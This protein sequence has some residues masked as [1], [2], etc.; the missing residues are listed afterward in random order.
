MKGE[1]KTG[2]WI[3][4]YLSAWTSN[5][6][7]EIGALFT[8]DAEYF[9]SPYRPPWSGREAIVGGWLERRD[10]PG[11]WRAQ[12]DVLIEDGELGVVQGETEYPNEGRTYSNLFLVWLDAEGQCTKFVEYF[13]EQD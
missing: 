9:T 2:Q 8:G 6:P 12:Y 7:A 5:D 4:V 13:M 1:T 10:E 11:T 3:K